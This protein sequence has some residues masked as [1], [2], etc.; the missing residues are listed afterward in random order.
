MFVCVIVCVCSYVVEVVWLRI[1]LG[2]VDPSQSE[3]SCLG[4]SALDSRGTLIRSDSQPQEM[5]GREAAHSTHVFL[6]WQGWGD[7]LKSS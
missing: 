5:M 2:P 1:V 4:S 7:R 6:V 3:R